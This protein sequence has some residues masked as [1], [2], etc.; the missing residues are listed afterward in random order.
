MEPFKS[1]RRNIMALI[2]MLR[3]VV[4][5]VNRNKQRIGLK[6][7]DHYRTQYVYILS[8]EY[9][10]QKRRNEISS[11]VSNL[12]V[13]KIFHKYIFSS[14]TQNLA[15]ADIYGKGHGV[16]NFVYTQQFAS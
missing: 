12:V 11:R 5:C 10:R 14:G 9:G 4:F 6:F 8:P 2:F 16:S 13:I 3:T 15:Y 1:F 7:K